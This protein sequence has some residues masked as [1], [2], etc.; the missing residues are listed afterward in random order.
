[1]RTHPLSCPTTR[2]LQGIAF[3][4]SALLGTAGCGNDSPTGPGV[5]VSAVVVSP[6]VDTVAVGG[7]AQFSATVFDTSGAPTGQ[8]VVW[9]SSDVGIFRVSGFGRV[10]G[11]AGGT[12]WLIGATG[13]QSDSA[14]VTVIPGNGWFVQAGA[15]TADLHGVF[16]LADGRTAWAVGDGGTVL[17]TTD[18]GGTWTRQTTNTA[19]NL[20]AVWFTDAASGW[21]VGA[22]GTVLRTTNG[23]LIWTRLSNIGQGDALTDVHFAGPDTGW[24]VGGAGLVLRTV[25]AGAHWEATRVAT[26][27]SLLGVSFSGTRDGWTVGVGGVIAGTHDRGQSWFVVPSITTQTLEAVSRRSPALAIAAGAQGLVPATVTTPDSVAWQLRNAGATFQLAGIH[28]PTDL[29]AYAV[30]FD[31]AQGGA[32]LRTDDGG[33]TWETQVSNTAFRLDDVHFVDAQRG[34]AVGAGGT[35]L[36]TARGGKP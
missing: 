33:L 16:A 31:A 14:R 20:N 11:V 35:I 7:T 15:T 22:S 34:W 2:G 27:F 1:M 4:L 9:S 32:V 28:A 25:D 19:F 18:A 29:I 26:A 12:A 30:G 8:G 10:T 36:H 23:G 6:A 13:G 5:P 24:V 21:A 3:L 17:R